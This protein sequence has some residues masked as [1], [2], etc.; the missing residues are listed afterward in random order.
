ME[1]RARRGRL[2]SRHRPERE[3]E[4]PAELGLHRLRRSV[5]LPTNELI[6]LI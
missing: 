5:A 1:R 6:G 2:P 3:G 4:A